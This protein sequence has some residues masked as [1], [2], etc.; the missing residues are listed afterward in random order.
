MVIDVETG[1]TDPSEHALLEVCATF[2]Q[3][4]GENIS[5]DDSLTWCIE[6]HPETSITQQ[7]LEINAIDPDDPGRNAIEEEEAIRDCY[8]TIRRE[9][10]LSGCS[11][12]V[13]TGHNAHFD[14]GFLFAAAA[15]NNVGQNPF[16]P[17]TVFDTASIGGIAVGHTV[18]SVAAERL[19]FCYDESQKHNAQYDAEMSARVFCEIVNRSN[20]WLVS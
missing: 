19:G 17:F 1:G 18:L 9:V 8:R 4:D 15:R 16:H 7:A 14:R 13:L 2:L 10:R 11:R 3:W 20:Y 6:P 5:L 12:A